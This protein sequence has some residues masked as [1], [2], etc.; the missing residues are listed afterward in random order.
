MHIEDIGFGNL[1]ISSRKWRSHSAS[2]LHLS[3]AI[4]LDSIVDLAI[5]ICFDDFHETIATP[6]VNT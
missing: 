2:S 1:G 6:N 3:S 5:T 4:N